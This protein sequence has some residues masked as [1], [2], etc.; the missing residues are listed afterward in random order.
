MLLSGGGFKGDRRNRRKSEGIGII[1]AI[2]GDR[3]NQRD[4]RGSE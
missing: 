4:R 1:G 2:G 3:S